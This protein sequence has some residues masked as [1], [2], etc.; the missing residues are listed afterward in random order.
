MNKKRYKMKSGFVWGQ[1]M[2]ICCYAMFQDWLGL[3]AYIEL[4]E[5]HWFN[6][7]WELWVFPIVACWLKGIERG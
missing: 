1:L 3:D 5:T 2:I 7:P 6:T 4:C